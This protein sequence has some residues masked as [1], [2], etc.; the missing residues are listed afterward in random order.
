MTIESTRENE[1][2]SPEA[3]GSGS[4]AQF[5]FVIGGD[6]HSINESSTLLSKHHANQVA[7]A[8]V[9]STGHGKPPTKVSSRFLLS[10]EQDAP[11]PMTRDDSHRELYAW[12]SNKES[13]TANHNLAL[14]EE[15]SMPFFSNYLKAHI[16][17]GPL[18]RAQSSHG[19]HGGKADLGTLLGVYLPTIQHI[20]GVT[21]F[22]RLFWLV[23]IAGLGQTF[24]LL[25]LCCL[26]TFLT[27]ISISAVATN[28]VVESGGAYFMIS[29]NLGPEFG[30]A[31][32]ILFYLANTVATSMYLVGGVE[33]LLL[34]IF[35][36]LTF[37][38]VE[39]QHDTGLFGNMTN[40]LRFYST[41]LLLIEFAIV[42]M[43]VKFVQMLAPVS[44]VCVILSILAC[45][46]GGVTKTMYPDS[47]QDVCF[48]GDTLL[49]S[50]VVLPAD[51]DLSE[52]CNYCGNNNTF[53]LDN[54]CA[55]T[56]CNDTIMTTSFRC[57]NGF[58]GFM[59]GQ[60]LLNNLAP[61]YV[62]K[63][64]STIHQEA[65]TKTDVY[66]DVRTTFFVLLA[67][68]FPAVTG[69]FTGANMSGDLKNPQASIPA[70][71]IAATLTT[72][73][74]YF[75]LAFVF[76]GAIDGA[77]LRDKNGQSVGGQ[78]V[79]A[80]L[81]WPNKWVLIIGSF[82]STFGAALQ[83]LCSAPR[84]LQAIAKD[85]VIPILS[86]F[87]KV[88]AKNEPFLGL[89]LTT[90]IAE[91]AILMGG[92]DTIA[93]VVDF[94]FLMCYAF[95]NIICTLH[96]LLGAPNWRPRFKY[97]HWF[98][99]LLGAV[100]C[101][102]IMFSTHWDY[103][104]VA[105]LLCLV[106]YK[107][108]E[109]KGAKKEW[110]DGIRGLALTT[111]QYSLM[112]IE[113]KEPHPKNWRPQL[114]LLLSMQWSKE[115]IDV[116][117]LNLLNLASQLKAGK[118]LTVVTAFLKGDPTSPDD[119]KKGEQ[120]KA[121]MDFDM[122]QVR[123]R[124]FAKTL[125]H[126]EDQI[127]GSM[128]T[129]VQSVGLG[130]LKP[131]TMLISWPVHEREEDMSEYNT[132]IEKVHAAAI[133][134]MAIVVAK[135]IIDFP[136]SVFRMSGMIDVYW[137]VQDGGLC[138]LLGYLLKQHKVW[139]GCKLRVIGIAQE[140]DNN[141]KM[142]ED[143]QKYVYQLRIDAKIMIVEL[144]DPE[145]SKNAFERTLLMEE[146]TMM[147]RDL[148]KAA[149]TGKTLSLPPQNAS[150][151]ISP[152]V[153]SEKEKNKEKIEKKDSEEDVVVEGN[154]SEEN[155]KTGGTGAGAEKTKK[156]RMKALDKSKVSKMHTAVRLNEL[157]LQHSA[158]SQLILLNLPKPP[159]HKEKRGLDDY[160][161]YL[162]VM[163]DKLNR[164]IFVRGTGKE[165]ITE[166]S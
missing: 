160:V 31:V 70:G 145:I 50:R 55:D 150:R 124:G 142:Q 53:L 129:L 16:T 109:W 131:N 80:L 133:N 74:I 106:I 61:N 23:G 161:H 54:I 27:C 162:E 91:L 135:G 92:M 37:G 166:N 121:R 29:R 24:L 79:V 155:E 87:A 18:E 7:P 75:S 43:G 28:G 59:G 93:A 134:D 58:P 123:L 86:P 148:Q 125:V 49:Q 112:K 113:D 95:V 163:T 149:G 4:G 137:I 3:G 159:L 119:K 5:N 105:C 11:P 151:A 153:T 83:C 118:G 69:I 68:Y 139:R 128:S 120:V 62:D 111:A 33:I 63:G 73:F 141:V 130:G 48:Y 72:S 90:I 81:S 39:G 165:V 110:G 47:G 2:T 77:V 158:N 94:F 6:E 60:T 44:L 21:M 156:E 116:R 25:F 132:F 26:C 41:I 51:V 38:G 40:S 20:L 89:I 136:S 42:A 127:F 96:S 57:V 107:Y 1:T 146:R 46:A 85:E 115:I 19:G 154:N 66:Q 56:G 104:T 157:L 76:G 30:S 152:L 35:P 17:P 164:V 45:Y 101:F 84:L 117:Y 126:E 71:T 67:I 108:V 32:G 13:G 34:Y 10:V 15:P 8:I 64:Y 100:L 65:N 97:Y 78:M 103:A 102:F 114:L 147:M 14:F 88:T 12:G 98:L 138:L 82:L 143:L 52:M 140:S 36:W 22:I 144:A 122:N 99:S 9:V